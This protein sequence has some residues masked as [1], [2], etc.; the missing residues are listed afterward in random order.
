MKT[1]RMLLMAMTAGVMAWGALGGYDS[2]V[3]VNGVDVGQVN[4]G[5][6]WNFDSAGR[7]NLKGANQR[8]S[9]TGSDRKGVGIR[10]KIE[11]DCIVA[12]N[13]LSLGPKSEHCNALWLDTSKKALKAKVHFTGQNDLRGGKGAAA[14]GVKEGQQLSIIGMAAS[15]KLLAQGGDG[16]AGIGGDDGEDRTEYSN[17][18]TVVIDGGYVQA[19]GGAGAAGIGGGGGNGKHAGGASGGHGGLVM[20][21]ES[22]CATEVYAKGGGYGLV[23]PYPGA[24]IGGGAYCRE[25]N[26]GEDCN[27][28]RL[29]VEKG[30]VTAISGGAYASGIGGAMGKDISGYMGMV[31]ITGGSVYAEGGAFA[32][33]IGA[34]AFA[35]LNSQFDF[36]MTGGR[37]QASFAN[38]SISGKRTGAGVGGTVETPGGSLSIYGGTLE[39][40]TI[41]SGYSEDGTGHYPFEANICGGSVMTDVSHYEARPVG[42]YGDEVY[43]LTI[44]GLPANRLLVVE[45]FKNVPGMQDYGL[46]DVYSNDKG[47]VCF[48]VTPGDYYLKIGASASSLQQYGVRVHDQGGISQLSWKTEQVEVT[49]D[50][51]GGMVTDQAG[52]GEPQKLGSL[53]KQ[54]FDKGV[55]YQQL[56]V[57]SAV[58]DGYTMKGWKCNHE[59][60]STTPITWTDTKFTATWEAIPD[61]SYTGCGGEAGSDPETTEPVMVTF[62]LNRYQYVPVKDLIEESVDLNWVKKISPSGLPSGLSFVKS[63][64]GIW[65]LE[66]VPS[67]LLDGENDY[68]VVNQGPPGQDLRL[69]AGRFVLRQAEEARHLWGDARRQA[70]QQGLLPLQDRAGSGEQNAGGPRVEDR[71]GQAR[72]QPGRPGRARV[73]AHGG[74]RRGISDFAR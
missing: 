8:F 40:Q 44:R 73:Q 47:E 33:S 31:Y 20:I 57:L 49:W 72:Q 36:I 70:G 23:W 50:A 43:A 45:G 32:A 42:K 38:N 19:T 2:G 67:K 56:P 16:G 15:D 58:R 5:K 63:S 6:G 35:L 66:G 27:G 9:I 53:Y 17:C 52:A 39:A 55:K 14:I 25:E 41:G 30:K 59:V 13:N 74:R 26:D 37:V 64:N 12:I 61:E 1:I 28:G 29:M 3:F 34:P 60:E 18:G 48:W 54:K 24:G 65:Y 68:A 21:V 4:S 46:K 11:A 51:N 22:E 7:I 71:P 62:T 10:I 69:R